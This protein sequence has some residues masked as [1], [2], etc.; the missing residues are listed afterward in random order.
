LDSNLLTD[1][2][3]S[4]P[5][6]Q[7]SA[8]SSTNEKKRVWPKEPGPART[9]FTNEE[10]SSDPHMDEEMSLRNSALL[11]HQEVSEGVPSPSNQ[12][13]DW[14]ER[15]Q[16]VLSCVEE[17]SSSYHVSYSSTSEK[18]DDASILSH[19]VNH[20]KHDNAGLFEGKRFFDVMETKT[21]TREDFIAV[22]NRGG[23]I[24]YIPWSA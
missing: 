9:G 15:A 1:A 23:S 18:G 22:V 4:D 17:Q 19:W 14:M 2:L 11:L 21:P 16:T 10:G 13:V 6:L 24:L 8:S 12:L 20:K 7:A 3:Q 5:I